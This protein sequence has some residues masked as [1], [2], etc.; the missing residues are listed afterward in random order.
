MFDKKSLKMVLIGLQTCYRPGREGM[1]IAANSH[2]MRGVGIDIRWIQT[3]IPGMLPWEKCYSA[4]NYWK[5][6]NNEVLNTE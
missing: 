4:T 1:Y 3:L 5:K 6:R 2:R